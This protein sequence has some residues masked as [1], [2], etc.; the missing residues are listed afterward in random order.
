MN[1]K[2][3]NI[4]ERR[5]IV[6]ERPLSQTMH[7]AAS[8]LRDFVETRVAMLLSEMREKLSNLKFAAPL[9][10]FGA[11]CMVSTWLL[12][13]GALVAVLNVVFAGSV[14]GPF[15]SLV[16]I[17]VLYAIAG[18]GA[19]WMAIGRIKK[20]GIIPKRTIEVLKEDK[21]WIENEARTQL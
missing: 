2:V 5:R 13:T 17:G 6:S 4:E 14:Y 1:S 19:L 9:L 11:L 7:E 12:I 20:Q 18:G 3:Y 16:I 8:E 15:L 10:A 21:V